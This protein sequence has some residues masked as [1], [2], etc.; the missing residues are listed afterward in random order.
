MAPLADPH[1]AE[2][3]RHRVREILLSTEGSREELI[4]ILQRIQAELD[5]VPRE[6]MVQ[7]SE[8]L[9][10]PVGEIHGVV[11]FYN[12][13]RLK[14]LGKYRIKVCL[15]TACHVKRSY[16]IMEEWKRRL[17][18]QEGETTEDRLFS[19]ERVACVGCC[20]LAPVIV[21]GTNH[22]ETFYGHTMTSKVGGLMMEFQKKEGGDGAK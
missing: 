1:E 18:V 5:Y 20:A 17:G 11:T 19:L 16:I 22:E 9:G 14:P 13:F 12:Q 10:I 3:I 6:A 7:V 2:R 8:S 15:G 21:V 4:P